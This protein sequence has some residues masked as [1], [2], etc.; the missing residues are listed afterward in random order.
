[1]CLCNNNNIE[2]V[3][4]GCDLILDSTMVVYRKRRLINTAIYYRLHKFCKNHWVFFFFCTS[5][6][7]VSAIFST[8]TIWFVGFPYWTEEWDSERWRVQHYWG[9]LPRFVFDTYT[10]TTMI[11][12]PE[13]CVRFITYTAHVQYIA[14][15]VQWR[16]F[17]QLYL[18]CRR[19]GT[20]GVLDCVTPN[21]GPWSDLPGTHSYS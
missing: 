8:Q 16:C 21:R 14:T 4:L 17:W 7:T 13:L 11:M 1:M 3:R 10:H 20:V 9:G 19:Q 2:V 12:W 15:V 5:C 18:L 6:S